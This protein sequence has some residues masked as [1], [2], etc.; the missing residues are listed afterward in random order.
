[1]SKVLILGEISSSWTYKCIKIP[2]LH[3]DHSIVLYGYDD[4][5][6]R[7]WY[8]KNGVKLV[9]PP[10]IGFL[11]RIPFFGK[12]FSKLAYVFGAAYICKRY[13]KIDCLHINFV[14]EKKLYTIPFCRKYCDKIICLF[15]GSDIF[16][17]DEVLEIR[18]SLVDGFFLT[19]DRM[20][21]RFRKLFGD[22]YI[23]K[24]ERIN[25]GIEGLDYISTDAGATVKNKKEF[26]VP[27]DRT[28]ITIGYNGSESQQHLRIIEA[29][30][31]LPE[32]LK[33]SVFLQ[34]PFTYGLTDE[35]KNIIVARLKRNGIEYQFIE[36]FMDEVTLGKF[37]TATDIFIHGQ[38]T[39]A[40][41]ASVKE[42]LYAQKIVLNG[43]WLTYEEMTRRGVFF[44]QFSDFDDLTRK[45]EYLLT[46]GITEDE[47]KRIANNAVILR[48]LY[49]WENV[50]SDWK[51]LYITQ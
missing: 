26:N 30:E 25:F 43:K 9:Y 49:S 48:S 15:W 4:P 51:K 7:D 34:F 33:N 46:K 47:R 8:I 37:R 16:R 39:D 2:E 14:D 24:I 6:Y 22:K 44:Y 32:N 17:K 20:E 28:V 12:R 1:M 35:Y 38:T 23:D 31:S 19:T 21:E 3:R 40:A 29:I 13:G 27:E 5:K 41:S 18:L 10:R 45:L 11:G 42:Y 50:S 36:R